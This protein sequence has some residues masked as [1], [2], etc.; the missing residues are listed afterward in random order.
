MDSDSKYPPK[1]MFADK[2]GQY[3]MEY[4]PDKLNTWEVLWE[5]YVN[6]RRFKNNELLYY[7][8][9]K[10]II[11]V[12]NLKILDV[13]FILHVINDHDDNNPA[14][15]EEARYFHTIHPRYQRE[16]N[17]F[18]S[19]NKKSWRKQAHAKKIHLQ[20]D[21]YFLAYKKHWVDTFAFGPSMR[22]FYHGVNLQEAKTLLDSIF[23]EVDKADEARA[24]ALGMSLEEYHGSYSNPPK[25]SIEKDQSKQKVVQ[26]KDESE[27]VSKIDT[28]R[29]VYIA[30]D[31]LFTIYILVMINVY[32][33]FENGLWERINTSFLAVVVMQLL[34][35]VP[36]GIIMG[37]YSL[38]NK[39]KL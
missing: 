2:D 38:I 18:L 37:I 27:N 5:R 22:L 1:L 39:R 14:D 32:N 8:H 6:R 16:I 29:S 21:P 35:L 26:Y 33:T 31:V 9:L 34:F 20:K 24:K 36:Y 17:A 30:I 12:K 3:Y 11:P 23:T 28:F 13:N 4:V 25:D 15:R 19:E 10:S 7:W